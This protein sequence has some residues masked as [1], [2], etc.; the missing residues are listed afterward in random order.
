[1]P[2]VW[3]YRRGAHTSVLAEVLSIGRTL[4]FPQGDDAAGA[5]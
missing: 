3:E 2:E 4:A 5:D 1:M